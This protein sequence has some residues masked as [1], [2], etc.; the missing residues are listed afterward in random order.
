M[1]F[2]FNGLILLHMSQMMCVLFKLAM[3]VSLSGD[4]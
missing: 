4:E 1:G 3:F 2:P